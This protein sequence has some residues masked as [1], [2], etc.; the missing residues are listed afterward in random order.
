MMAMLYMADAFIEKVG[1][2]LPRKL[3]KFVGNM[4]PQ[5]VRAAYA[6]LVPPELKTMLERAYARESITGAMIEEMAGSIRFG[7]ELIAPR[8]TEMLT[9]VRLKKKRLKK[10]TIQ[11]MLALGEKLIQ[12]PGVVTE[13]KNRIQGFVEGYL[14][15][16]ESGMADER[17]FTEAERWT[18]K[19]NIAY[20]LQNLPIK[21]LKAGS[22][23]SIAR[24]FYAFMSIH[25]AILHMSGHAVRAKG[26]RWDRKAMAVTYGT[27]SWV[28]LAGGTAVPMWWLFEWFW[29]L[30]TD[31]PNPVEWARK[32]ENIPWATVRQ[33]FDAGITSFAGVDLRHTLGVGD[34]NPFDLSGRVP[35]AA[36]E[37]SKGMVEELQ[38][39]D[40]RGAAQKAPLFVP[41][42]LRAQ[43][44]LAESEE[45]GIRRGSKVIVPAK[46]LTTE[47][48]IAMRFGL[49][50]YDVGKKYEEEEELY[51]AR[52][53]RAKT[54][55]RLTDAYAEAIF[56]KD[57]EER[58]ATLEKIRQYNK[59]VQ[60]DNPAFVIDSDALESAILRRVGALKYGTEATESLRQ[61]SARE[62]IRERVMVDE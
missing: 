39:G 38:R 47:Q 25:S 36:W 46:D 23:R 62:R 7:G 48:R 31:A 34:I 2:R 28:L 29:D 5:Q 14:L 55:D 37:R 20:G 11:S 15:G 27:L 8:T 49:T 53:E 4:T 17:L 51:Q 54:F 19:V 21:I 50:P 57:T 56:L 32:E 58:K 52:A 41:P 16:K 42:L 1:A 22:L 45:L 10:E 3:A 26:V 9:H 40:V 6:R 18:E 33:I 61:R 59:E 35:A 12:L 44:K 24:L 60:V 13:K 43:L 30:F